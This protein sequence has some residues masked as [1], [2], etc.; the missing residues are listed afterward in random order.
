MKRLFLLA[1][2]LLVLALTPATATAA[3]TRLIQL[4]KL[5]VS[6][7]KVT[8]GFK[9]DNPDGAVSATV[10]LLINGVEVASQTGS[11]SGFVAKFAIDL[12]AGDFTISGDITVGSEILSDSTTIH[13]EG[14]TK[15]KSDKRICFAPGEAPAAVYTRGGLEV[16]AIDAND[17]GVLVMDVR[18]RRIR[19]LPAFPAR[20]MPIERSTTLVQVEF[21][22]NPD[23]G[24][25]LNVGPDAEGK[26][27]E[28]LFRFTA[29]EDAIVRTW[30]AR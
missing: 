28:C 30:I 12:P 21:M 10:R 27:F 25:Q 4:K 20:V 13:C 15:T 11:P 9:S 5:V 6:C 26:V 24:F 8:V 18:E 29:P 1:V 16:W 3:D 14:K 2:L 19:D 23:G 7:K 22:K 17:E